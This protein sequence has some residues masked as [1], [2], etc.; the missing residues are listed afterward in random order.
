MT[1]PL[2]HPLCIVSG[3]RAIEIQVSQMATK[4]IPSAG[5]ALSPDEP[6]GYVLIRVAL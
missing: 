4:W 2:R 6:G 5:F 3:P 1:A